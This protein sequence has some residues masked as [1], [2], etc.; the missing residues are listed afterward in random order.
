MPSLDEQLG[1]YALSQILMGG[2]GAPINKTLLESGLGEGMCAAGISSG[3]RQLS[4]SIGL[5]GVKEPDCGAVEKLILESVTQAAARG[6]S[7]DEIEAAL[8]TLEFSMRESNSGRYPR[9]F[10]PINNATEEWLYGCD[11]IAALRWAL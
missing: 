4:C 2:S 7:A 6:I 11:P 1:L 5:K 9:G 10:I 8:N 3:R